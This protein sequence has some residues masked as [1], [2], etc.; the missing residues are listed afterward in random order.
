MRDPKRIKPILEKLEIIWNKNPD[1]RFGQL[2]DN[3]INTR[4]DIFYV[5]DTLFEKRIDEFLKTGEFKSR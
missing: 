3:L 4:A 1:F 5:E 2:V